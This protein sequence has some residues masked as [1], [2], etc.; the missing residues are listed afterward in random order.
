[1]QNPVEKNGYIIEKPLAFGKGEINNLHKEVEEK[2]GPQDRGQKQRELFAQAGDP[3]EK[4][5]EEK[6]AMPLS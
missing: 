2:D 1:M 6:P 3:H 4:E 5:K